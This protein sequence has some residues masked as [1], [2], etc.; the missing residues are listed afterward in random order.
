MTILKVQL[1]DYDV[2]LLFYYFR[3]TRSREAVEKVVHGDHTKVHDGRPSPLLSPPGQLHGVQKVRHRLRHHGDL[4]VH[5]HVHQPPDSEGLGEGDGLLGPGGGVEARDVNGLD[6]QDRHPGIGCVEVDP[7]GDH[8]DRQTAVGD[9][10]AGVVGAGGL[11]VGQLGPGPG[12]KRDLSN[13]F[14]YHHIKSFLEICEKES[15]QKGI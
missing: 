7:A 6:G 3:V 1:R 10:A 9:R 2:E 14:Q 5:P 11:E 15:S 12:K 13:G 8:E 4:S